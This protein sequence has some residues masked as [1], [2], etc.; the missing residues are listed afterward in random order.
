M[1]KVELTEAERK[2]KNQYLKN[3]HNRPENKEKRKQYM[4]NYWSKKV[5]AMEENN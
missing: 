1:S 2:A 4:K 5:Q 3:W